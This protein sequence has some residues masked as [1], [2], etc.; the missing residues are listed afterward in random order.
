VEVRCWDERSQRLS[1]R[2]LATA[3]RGLELE[4]LQEEQRDI[5]GRRHTA[6][7]NVSTSL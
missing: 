5:S 4:V 1:D 7:Q 3:K 2:G 6:L